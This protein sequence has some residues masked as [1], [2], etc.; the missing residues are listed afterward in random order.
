MGILNTYTR[1]FCG[2]ALWYT[3]GVGIGLNDTGLQF[4]S[5]SYF[6]NCSLKYVSL[7]LPFL[8]LNVFFFLFFFFLVL[9]RVILLFCSLLGF[10]LSFFCPNVL[11]QQ[12]L[13]PFVLNA[14]VILGFSL[15]RRKH[16][17]EISIYKEVKSP[18]VKS[19]KNYFR[20]IILK[21]V[22]FVWTSGSSLLQFLFDRTFPREKV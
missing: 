2:P 4:V 13:K 8:C 20:Y 6:F 1:G 5:Y 14:I 17:R 16:T 19:I 3:H 7:G 9:F 18:V 10:H 21:D 12:L 15:M 11:G 22:L